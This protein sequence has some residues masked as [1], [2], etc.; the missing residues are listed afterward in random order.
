MIEKG[1]RDGALFNCIGLG[2]VMMISMCE[3]LFGD[4]QNDFAF[5]AT[6]L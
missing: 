2:A 5:E 4:G 1:R 6:L 3:G